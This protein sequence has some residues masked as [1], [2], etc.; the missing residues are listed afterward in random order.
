MLEVI[1]LAAG[2]GSRMRSPLPKVLHCLA[3]KPLVQHVID[4]ARALN[5]AQ[6]HVVVGHEAAQVSAA[7][8]A[9][10]VQCHEQTE[11][12]GTGHAVSVA[13][14]A[15]SDS[16]TV[17]VLYG[18]VPLIGETTLRS[19]VDAA[20]TGFALLS[21]VLSDPTGYGRVQR[22][23]SG[24][25]VAV[26][27]A[28][29]ADAVTRAVS[30]VNTGVLAGPALQMKQ[31]LAQVTNNNA[32]G[33][34]YLPDA[35]KVAVSAGEPVSVMSTDDAGSV[36]G[37]N[38]LR[39]LHQLERQL[40]VNQAEQL[41]LS[42]VSVADTA[43]LDI[44]GQLT[45]G[46]GVSIDVGCV[47]EGTVVLGDGVSIG[48]HCVIRDA[49]IGP[50][51]R[52]EAF[53]HIEGAQ[54]GTAVAAGPYAR[55]RP[56]AALDT[57]SKIGNFVEV[58]NARLGAG[59]KANHLAYIGDADIGADSNIGAGTITCNYDGAHKHRTELGDNVFIGSNST[60]V[61]PVVIEAGAF[62]A[63]GSTI[64]EAV[65]SEQLA[66]GRSR[67]RNIDGWLRPTKPVKD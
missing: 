52:V 6:I 46:V 39:Q 2:Q 56:G 50:G 44:R 19:L 9:S 49:E 61:A 4:L 22:D 34:Y 43:R 28:K 48:P 64:T 10:D 33:E 51:A 12:L 15:V 65:A 7:I 37:V 57:G 36:Q 27:E 25:F 58:K 3:G 20:E 45:C 62:V 35:L 63:A 38:D 40:Q 16:A 55:L 66:V 5:P 31:C 21:A 30:E 17:L 32:Q 18:D 42:G 29:D 24:A 53:C 59:A 47:F 1:I 41:L 14:P 8:A 13:L 26:V 67:Q 54:L 11:Q 23:A 60:L